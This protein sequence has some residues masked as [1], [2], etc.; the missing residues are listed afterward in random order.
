MTPRENCYIL[1][2]IGPN[3]IYKDI[4][5]REWNLILVVR[6]LDS[7]DETVTC[8]SSYN[9]VVLD[10]T[11]TCHLGNTIISPNW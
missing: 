6:V 5:K 8:G 9:F 7:E 1:G 11:V 4:P 10:S 2:Y 3:D